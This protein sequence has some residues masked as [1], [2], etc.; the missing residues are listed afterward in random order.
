MTRD[1]AIGLAALMHSYWPNWSLPANDAEVDLTLGAWVRLCGEEVPGPAM[2]AALDVLAAAG[3]PFPPPIGLVRKRAVELLGA[4]DGERVPDAD[5]AWAEVQDV[6]GR[7]GFMLG[8]A[9]VW[10]H[11]A[12][13][14]A[15]DAIG[16][17]RL[18]FDENQPTL[19]AQFRDAYRPAAVRAHEAQVVPPVAAALVAD[20]AALMR[21]RTLELT[22]GDDV[23][24]G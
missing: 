4:A 2:V 10:S 22:G 7:L 6:I 23:V 12:V 18:C 17:W 1:E 14:D 9:T 16:W 19:F 15:V 8:A 5:Q 21:A 11:P 20:T 3:E 24:V 13:G